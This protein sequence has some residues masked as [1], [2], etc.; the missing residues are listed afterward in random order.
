MQTKY[1][2]RWRTDGSPGIRWYIMGILPNGRFYGDILDREARRGTSVAGDVP[3]CQR[4]WEILRLIGS[5]PAIEPQPCFA[6]LGRYTVN[7]GRSEIVF[8]YRLGDE[9]ES[10]AAQ[11]FLELI[12]LL[13]PEVSKAYARL[14]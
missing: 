2:I 1:A 13:E 9:W 11:A 8:E 6:R 4:V 5:G 10:P 12:K 7:L 14:A 3:D